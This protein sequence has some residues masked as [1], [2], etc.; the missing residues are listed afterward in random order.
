MNALALLFDWQGGDCF[1]CARPT[2]LL[3]QETFEA[4]ADRLG[5]KRTKGW[6]KEFKRRQATL[7]HLTRRIDGGLNEPGNLVMACCWCNSTRG[8]RP[9]LV[10][11]ANMRRERATD[12]AL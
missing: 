4:A 1:Y 2:W 9:V 6:R 3:G 5:I 8:A 10:H 12:G 11:L 7:E